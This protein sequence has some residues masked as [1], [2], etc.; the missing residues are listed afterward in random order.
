M[1][2]KYVI[3][4]DEIT[5]VTT[6]YIAQLLGTV[7]KLN[8]LYIEFPTPAEAK[9][10][11]DELVARAEEAE[12]QGKFNYIV[13]NRILVAGGKIFELAGNTIRTTE[14][15]LITSIPKAQQIFSV[16]KTIN[17]DNTISFAIPTNLGGEGSGEC[18]CFYGTKKPATNINPPKVGAL[19]INTASGELWVCIKNEQNKNWWKNIVTGEI[20]KPLKK[21][22]WTEENISQPTKAVVSLP[23]AV[24]I[25]LYGHGWNSGNYHYLF[26]SY[27]SN[28]GWGNDMYYG[29]GFTVRQNCGFNYQ[30]INTP[31]S[32]NQDL[33]AIVAWDSNGWELSFFTKDANGNWNET[34]HKTGGLKW[35][36]ADYV[37]LYADKCGNPTAPLG[38]TIYKAEIYDSRIPHDQ[39]TNYVSRITQD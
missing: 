33:V 27:H 3:Y 24:T 38:G 31:P 11:F 21:P 19:Y 35:C 12:Q 7:V 30:Y 17:W 18:L 6:D 16:L 28:G 9:D 13:K 20:V 25:I 32:G 5:L 4:K 26:R 2:K 36:G 34:Y 8:S 29:N 23:T 37:C 10:F 39:F 14:G 22:I 1:G 15:E